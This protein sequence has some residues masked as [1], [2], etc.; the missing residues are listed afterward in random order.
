LGE[1]TDS[2]IIMH[3]DN[4]FRFSIGSEYQMEN[5]DFRFGYYYDESPIPESTLSPTWP[6]MNTMHSLNSGFGYRFN[7]YQLDA[8][9]EYILF[10]ERIIDEAN[11]QENFLGKYNANILAFNLGITYNFK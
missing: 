6:D 2:E 9:L 5:I 8:G 1:V 4:T 3:W 11:G 10:P 7:Q